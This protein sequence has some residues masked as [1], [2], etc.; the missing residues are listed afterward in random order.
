MVVY[1][2]LGKEDGAKLTRAAFAVILKFSDTLDDFIELEDQVTSKL[3]AMGK[4]ELGKDEALIKFIKDE[5]KY[6]AIINRFQTASR[7][8]QWINEKKLSISEKLEKDIRAELRQ[9][10]I[11][12]PRKQVETQIDSTVGSETQFQDLTIDESEVTKIMDSRVSEKMQEV[13]TKI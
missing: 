9:K 4:Q 3:N 6:E 11:K 12:E 13:Y 8:R 5:P 2:R 10:K 1:A 7:M